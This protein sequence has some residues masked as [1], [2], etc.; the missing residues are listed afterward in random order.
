METLMIVDIILM[1][2][3]IICSV[4]IIFIL[5]KKLPFLAAI[6]PEQFSKTKQMAI[7]N[8]IL[9]ERLKKILVET[10]RRLTIGLSNFN[11]KKNKEKS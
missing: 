3:I 6:S 11:S 10:K 2:I 9:K 1:A 4:S 7:K 8:L 5:V